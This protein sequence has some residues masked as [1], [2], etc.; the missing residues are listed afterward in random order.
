MNPTVYNATIRIGSGDETYPSS[1]DRILGRGRGE[2]RPPVSQIDV[3]AAV[4]L[5][6]KTAL[7]FT[8]PKNP[9]VEHTTTNTGAGVALDPSPWDW[10]LCTRWGNTQP[11][12]VKMNITAVAGLGSKAALGLAIFNK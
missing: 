2:S 10:I 9:M 4:A 1:C 8:I 12:V 3:T 11:S 5:G 6:S 7:G